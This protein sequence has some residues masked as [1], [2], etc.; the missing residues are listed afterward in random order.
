MGGEETVYSVVFLQVS[1]YNSILSHH[2]ESVLV[3]APGE[4]N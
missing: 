2:V 3:E 4:K 1:Y